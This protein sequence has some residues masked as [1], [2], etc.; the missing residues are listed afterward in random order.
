MRLAILNSQVEST[1]PK[2]IVKYLLSEGL[3]AAL[4]SLGRAKLKT[5]L[6]KKHQALLNDEKLKNLLSVAEKYDISLISNSPEVKKWWISLFDYFKIPASE[7]KELLRSIV[8]KAQPKLEKRKDLTT[9]RYRRNVG[10]TLRSRGISDAGIDKILSALK[11]IKENK[12]TLPVVE[13][14]VKS[15]RGFGAEWIL[16]DKIVTVLSESGG[17]R[18]LLMNIIDIGTDKGVY[19]TLLTKNNNKLI[20][21]LAINYIVDFVEVKLKQAAYSQNDQQTELWARSINLKPKAKATKQEDDDIH[22]GNSSNQQHGNVDNTIDHSTSDIDRATGQRK[23]VLAKH[24]S[25]LLWRF[26]RMRAAG[27][28]VGKQLTADDVRSTEDK[29]REL[30]YKLKWNKDLSKEPELIKI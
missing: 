16:S 17:L 14:S 9:N 24:L 25:S 2:L 27:N 26:V 18:D 22:A 12:V 15:L 28:P 20:A 30:G 13:N 23:I 19:G 1:S 3:S 10:K 29:L 6:A 11:K 8:E 5:I 4:L 7:R 21:Q